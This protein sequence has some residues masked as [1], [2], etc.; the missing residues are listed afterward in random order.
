MPRWTRKQSTDITLIVVCLTCKYG[1]IQLWVYASSALLMWAIM[2]LLHHIGHCFGPRPLW[3]T[4]PF[5]LLPVWVGFVTL[6]DT[7][8]QLVRRGEIRMYQ[9]CDW[10][11]WFTNVTNHKKKKKNVCWTLLNYQFEHFNVRF[12]LQPQCYFK[13]RKTPVQ[14]LHHCSRMPL[15]ISWGFL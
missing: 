2:L 4:H 8:Y 11:L 9:K 13:H 5:I 6:C 15:L 1:N 10:K 14:C 3:R 12:C 7:V